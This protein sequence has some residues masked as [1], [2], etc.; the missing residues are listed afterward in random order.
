MLLSIVLES[1]SYLAQIILSPFDKGKSDFTC[2][3]FLHIMNPEFSNF[4]AD[5]RRR[6]LSHKSAPLTFRLLSPQPCV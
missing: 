3:D 2:Q 5:S 6:L 4:E 1:F